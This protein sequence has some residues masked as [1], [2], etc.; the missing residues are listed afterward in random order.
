MLISFYFRFATDKTHLPYGV[1]IVILQM[2]FQ[3]RLHLRLYDD[4]LLIF[5]HDQCV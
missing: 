3:L 1:E 4:W 5:V 2:T